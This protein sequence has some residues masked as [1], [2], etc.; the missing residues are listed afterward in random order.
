[1]IRLEPWPG[2]NGALAGPFAGGGGDIREK[3]KW[4]SLEEVDWGKMMKEFRDPETC[5]KTM[6]SPASLVVPEEVLAG[7]EFVQYMNGWHQHAPQQECD[8]EG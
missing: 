5:R 3:Q 8:E 4:N 1:M 2:P 7:Q 6:T